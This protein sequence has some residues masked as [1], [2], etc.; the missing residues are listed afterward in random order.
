MKKWKRKNRKTRNWKKKISYLK[1][2][3]ITMAH[4]VMDQHLNQSQSQSRNLILTL[5]SGYR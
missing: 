5:R 3:R 1:L 2:L 4:M